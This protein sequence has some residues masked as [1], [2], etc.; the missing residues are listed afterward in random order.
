[1]TLAHSRT[2][3]DGVRE[4]NMPAC[5]LVGNRLS[6]DETSLGA[7]DAI[8]VRNLAY[9]YDARYQL[10]REAWGDTCPP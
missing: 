6:I 5:D 2:R 8:T 10:V 7:D 1:M 3:R 4:S 9:E